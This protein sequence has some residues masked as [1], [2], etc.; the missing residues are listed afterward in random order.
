MNEIK[1][2]LKAWEEGGY[3]NPDGLEAAFNAMTFL[4]ARVEALEETVKTLT[5]KE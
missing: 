2:L 3:V 1:E 4:V 5:S